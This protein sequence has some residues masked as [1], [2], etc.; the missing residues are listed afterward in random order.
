MALSVD[1]TLIKRRTLDGSPSVKSAQFQLDY[2]DGV[3]TYATGI[4]LN[5]ASLGL[6]NY[7]EELSF[8]DMGSDDGFVYKF[9]ASAN[10]IRIYEEGD[11][12]GELVELASGATP[13]GSL[14]VVVKGY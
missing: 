12:S 4:A 14:L 8:N 10:S 6:P 13:Q 3:E 7:L 11:A 1:Y 2:G 9:D 5:I